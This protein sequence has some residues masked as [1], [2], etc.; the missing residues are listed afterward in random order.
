MKNP[1]KSIYLASPYGFTDSGIFF[2]EKKIL[3]LIETKFK[4]LNPWSNMNEIGNEIGNIREKNQQVKDLRKKLAILNYKIGL[5]NK[6]L[7]DKC[8]IVL[9]I[10]DGIDVDS[11]VAAEIGYAFGNNKKIIG[12]RSDFRQSGDN[13]GSVINLQVEFFIKKSGGKILKNLSELNSLTNF[14]SSL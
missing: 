1:K 2:M 13:E 10:L 6:K 4:I 14:T 3:P 12:Y 9:A 5:Q 8:D 7:I 11:G